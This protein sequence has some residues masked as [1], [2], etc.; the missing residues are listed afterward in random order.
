MGLSTQ[1]RKCV[2]FTQ[3]WSSDSSISLQKLE[4]SKI[5]NFIHWNTHAYSK[6]TACTAHQEENTQLISTTNFFV[7]V[8]LLQS[9]NRYQIKSN[10][11]HATLFANTLTSLENQQNLWRAVA[12]IF[13]CFRQI[14]SLF[15]WE[16]HCDRMKKKHIRMHVR[17]RKNRAQ[18]DMIRMLPAKKWRDDTCGIH[19]LTITPYCRR[20]HHLFLPPSSLFIHIKH[21][22]YFTIYFCQSCEWRFFYLQLS[23]ILFHS[24][25]F[26][27]V[28]RGIRLCF[29]CQHSMRVRVW[30]KCSAYPISHHY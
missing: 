8:S 11:F 26:A 6:L 24:N 28:K 14:I 13:A 17:E 12:F 19:N 10:S 23:C 7:V 5:P 20:Y 1:S 4:V 25:V 29:M 15:C 18:H 3:K 9:D 30:L 2:Y 22:F 16:R 21:Q 27:L